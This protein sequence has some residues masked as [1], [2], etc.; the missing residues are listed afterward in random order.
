MR[1]ASGRRPL[2]NFVPDNWP[3]RNARNQL[4]NEGFFHQS[5]PDHFFVSPQRRFS[6]F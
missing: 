6:L 2:D 4:T 5:P 3:I 1:I